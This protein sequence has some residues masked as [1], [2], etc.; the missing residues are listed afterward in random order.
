MF[1]VD[2]G[3]GAQPSSVDDQG[4]PGV[5]RRRAG[6]A[7]L[8]TNSRF[9]SNF[10]ATLVCRSHGELVID[11][12]E[13]SLYQGYQAG[14]SKTSLLV[15]YRTAS[16]TFSNEARACLNTGHA[17]TVTREDH[18]FIAVTAVQPCARRTH[19][20]SSTSRALARRCSKSHADSAM[21][22]ALLVAS[23]SALEGAYAPAS[24][25]GSQKPET[26][27]CSS[28]R[29]RRAR[30][31]LREAMWPVGAAIEALL[32]DIDAKNVI[33]CLPF[34]TGKDCATFGLRR[35]ERGDAWALGSAANV[36]SCGAAAEALDDNR[37]GGAFSLRC[38]ELA[39]DADVEDGVEPRRLRV[40]GGI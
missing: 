30:D 39:V 37:D 13:A 10:D 8:T 35:Y 38:A 40:R 34:A 12:D 28:S 21:L 5:P 23:A 2:S 6:R 25:S 20:L 36:G 32:N 3:A 33:C 1:A 22:A 16:S 31:R 17:S 19:L 27:P 24:C 7:L 9:A 4:K 15:S 18:K 26:R 11:L 14:H 29:R